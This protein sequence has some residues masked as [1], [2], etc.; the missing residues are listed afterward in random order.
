VRSF[1][2]IAIKIIV[3]EDSAA[4]GG[5]PYSPLGDPV[6]IEGFCHQPVSDSVAAARAVM[7]HGIVE[8]FGLG[9]NGFHNEFPCET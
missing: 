9:K 4:H 7:H 3:H 6:I 8:C 2:D 5:N 1:L